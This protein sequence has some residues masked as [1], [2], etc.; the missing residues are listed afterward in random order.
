MHTDHSKIEVNHAGQI[1]AWCSNNGQAQDGQPTPTR[2]N[3]YGRYLLWR[4]LFP[5]MPPTKIARRANNHP[6]TIEPDSGHKQTPQPVP[7]DPL[8]GAV[9]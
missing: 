2:C 9:R 4:N 5:E 7:V 3:A 1:T 6:N 8:P